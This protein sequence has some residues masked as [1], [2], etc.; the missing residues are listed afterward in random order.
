MT[1]HDEAVRIA[2]LKAETARRHQEAIDQ[3]A[4]EEREALL[5]RLH[6]AAAETLAALEAHGYP[7]VRLITVFEF[8]D[9]TDRGHASEPK[10]KVGELGGWLLTSSVAYR[11]TGE[12]RYGLFLLSDG[13]FAPLVSIPVTGPVPAEVSVPMDGIRTVEQLGAKE[14]NA[15]PPLL[16]HLSDTVIT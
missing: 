14:L 2:R 13:R 1:L 7:E 3:Q 16:R 6:R 15:W 12:Q 5:D 4:A 10:V 8:R 11:R 9:T